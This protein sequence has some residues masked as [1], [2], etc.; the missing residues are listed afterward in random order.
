MGAA[1]SRRRRD[2]VPDHGRVR[3]LYYFCRRL[4]LLHR[5]EPERTDAGAGAGAAD[6]GHGVSAFEQRHGSFRGECTA[7]K[8]HSQLHAWLA[9]TVLLGALFLMGT[10]REWYH[11]IHDFGL[12][13]RTNLFGTTF[14]SLVGLHATHVVIGLIMLTTALALLAEWAREREACRA[15]GGVVAVLAL[16]GWRLGCCVSGCLCAGQIEFC[17]V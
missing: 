8:Q 4:H 11:L 6:P 14:Y 17:D 13:I 15:A 12:T 9:G 5:Q 7:Q 2:G 3:D 1:A 16:C 10:A